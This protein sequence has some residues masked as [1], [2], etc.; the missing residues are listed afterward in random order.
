MRTRFDLQ[1]WLPTALQQ[2]I[3]DTFGQAIDG[4]NGFM[5]QEVSSGMDLAVKYDVRDGFA[6]DILVSDEFEERWLSELRYAS[7]GWFR[8]YAFSRDRKTV[9]FVCAPLSDDC[10]DVRDVAYFEPFAVSSASFAAHHAGEHAPEDSMRDILEAFRLWLYL[11]MENVDLASRIRHDVTDYFD[12]CGNRRPCH[13]AMTDTEIMQRL[14]ILSALRRKSALGDRDSPFLRHPEMLD[15]H[16][17]V[18]PSP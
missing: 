6:W 1:K 12:V 2:C 4:A 11:L 9:S 16:F 18:R 15:V 5:L 7:G 3:A 14:S 13:A 8:L 10:L 17:A